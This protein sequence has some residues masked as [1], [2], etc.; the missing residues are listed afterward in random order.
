V[1][2]EQRQRALNVIACTQHALDRGV[3]HFDR[4]GKRLK[5][6]SAIIEAWARGSGLVVKEPE[7]GELI[8][9]WTRVKE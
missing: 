9:R 3:Q 8:T 4:S 5:S 6:V 2:E 1:N 7:R